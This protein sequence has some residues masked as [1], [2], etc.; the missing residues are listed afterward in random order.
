MPKGENYVD[1]GVEK[2]QKWLDEMA[3]NL[4]MDGI[5][6][7]QRGPNN[8]G[9]GPDYGPEGPGPV[10][11]SVEDAAGSLLSQFGKE[12]LVGQPNQQNHDGAG[13]SNFG[14]LPGATNTDPLEGSA[15][16]GVTRDE[17]VDVSIHTGMKQNADDEENDNQT[18]TEY[19]IKKQQIKLNS[20][21]TGNSQ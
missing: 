16:N 9:K 11:V 4:G 7:H 19:H 2:K 1:P 15:Y 20:K 14:G 21:I 3:K 17:E 18:S 13:P 8:Q 10:G 6:N 5:W 12:G